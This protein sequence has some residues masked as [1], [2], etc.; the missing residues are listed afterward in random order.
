MNVS[1]PRSDLPSPIPDTLHSIHI[2]VIASLQ[3]IWLTV[4]T[5]KQMKRVPGKIVDGV[6]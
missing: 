1:E 5:G 2:D 6:L 4:D 3:S